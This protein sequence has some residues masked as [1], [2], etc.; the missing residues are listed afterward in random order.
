MN[1]SQESKNVWTNVYGLG[2]SVLALGTLLTLVFNDYRTLFRPVNLTMR[3]IQP[4]ALQKLNLFFLFESRPYLAQALAV[5]ILAVT[6]AGWRPRL[7][8]V[9]HAWVATSLASACLPPGDGVKV[10]HSC[11]RRGR[12]VGSWVQCSSWRHPG[13]FLCLGGPRRRP[14]CPRTGGSTVWQTPGRAK[15][16]CPGSDQ[17]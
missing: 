6:V 5:L 1:T 4:V 8:G 13:W 2:R 14:W 17:P 12:C 3:D 16:F 7:T 10:N 15:G 11:T 9:L